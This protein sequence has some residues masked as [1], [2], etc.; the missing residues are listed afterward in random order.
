MDAAECASLIAI[1]NN[2][3]IYGPMSTITFEQEDGSTK[4][5]RQLNKE[6]QELI[7]LRMAGGNEEVGITRPGL[8][9]GGG[10]TGIHQRGA[11]L[12]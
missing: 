8:P 3:S 4:T 5:A 1:T 9:L 12:H 10:G 2:P 6:R 11:A 7:L